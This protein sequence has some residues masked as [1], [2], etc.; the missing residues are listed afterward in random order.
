M[1]LVDRLPAT[2]VIVRVVA[3]ACQAATIA[4]TWQLWESRT[5]P[6]NLPVVGFLGG[7]DYALPLLVM[8]LAC[9][10]IPRVAT[11]VFL[12]LLTAAVLGDQTRIQPEVISLTLL[13][14]LPMLGENGIRIARWHL[15]GLW[16]WSGLNKALSSGWS[17]GAAAFIAS[18]LHLPSARPLVAVALPAAEIAL[19][20]TS[21][22][23]RTWPVTR[24]GAVAVHLGIFLT[25]SP[26]FAGWNSSV[27]PWNVGLAVAGFVLFNPAEAPVEKP[28]PYVGVAAAI[29]LVTPALWYAGITDAYLSHNLY[30]TNTALGEICGTNGPCSDMQL[31]TYSVT[32]VPLPPE[33]RLYRAQ[34]NDECTPEMVLRYTGP[35]TVFSDPPVHK[36]YA[37]PTRSF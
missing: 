36:T 4:L 7:I 8:A 17:K 27:W 32:N 1:R 34:F 33:E 2:D 9:I 14:A 23:R 29:F 11:P 13:M 10:V 16:L 30:T 37:C 18:S 28:A 26:L 25:L 21:L 15:T 6:P 22:S 31:N 12:V 20:L 35:A 5:L 19:A 24:W 3:A